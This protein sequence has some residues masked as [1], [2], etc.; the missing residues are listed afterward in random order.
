MRKGHSHIHTQFR[1]QHDHMQETALHEDI[2]LR[3]QIKTHITIHDI[4]YKV[5]FVFQ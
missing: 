2:M 5:L 4:G 3:L 1:Q